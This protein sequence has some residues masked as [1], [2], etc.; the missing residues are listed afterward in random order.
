MRGADG[1]VGAD[2]EHWLR[3]SGLVQRRRSVGNF[4][5]KSLARG[6]LLHAHQGKQSSSASRGH[7]WNHLAID[8]LQPYAG[9]L[10]HPQCPQA[11]IKPQ[12]AARTI[13]RR[14]LS[15]SNRV[16]V[17][18]EGMSISSA[19]R[20]MAWSGCGWKETAMVVLH[21]TLL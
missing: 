20:R 14:A 3:E 13:P 1:A 6:A 21:P 5:H 17:C 15:W 12:S 9:R 4:Y 7:R 2:L 16:S 19:L 10:F 11:D 18:M 8:S